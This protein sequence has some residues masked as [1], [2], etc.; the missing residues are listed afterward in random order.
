MSSHNNY[1]SFQMKTIY[2]RTSKNTTLTKKILPINSFFDMLVISNICLSIAC[3]VYCL[4][5]KISNECNIY[6]RKLLNVNCHISDTHGKKAI[7]KTTIVPHR[8]NEIFIPIHQGLCS[9][10]WTI[11]SSLSL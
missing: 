9:V 8:E 6:R 7:L 5:L 3:F 1:M 10:L 2:Q 11:S 4:F